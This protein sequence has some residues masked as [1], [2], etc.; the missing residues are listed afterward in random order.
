M[1]ST[2]DRKNGLILWVLLVLL[3]A[4]S[5]ESAFAQASL[6]SHEAIFLRSLELQGALD[7]PFLGYRSLDDETWDHT[8]LIS[9]NLLRY[10]LPSISEIGAFD[11]ELY[12]AD[13]YA[14]YNSA[15]PHGMND[16]A[17]WQGVGFN[18]TFSGGF[19]LQVRNL[20]LTFKPQLLFM[21]NQDFDIMP[22]A[23]P[24]SD[25][26]GYFRGGQDLNQ[27]PGPDSIYDWSW[28][29][30]ELRFNWKNATIGFGTQAVWLGPGLSNAIILTNNAPP[31]PKLD[32]GMRKTETLIGEVEARA[33]WGRMTESDWFNDDEGDDYTLL[34]G[35][36]VAWSPVF[37][38][39]LTLGF[40]RTMLSAWTDQDWDG[41][42]EILVPLMDV[43]MGLDRRDQ[44]A[45]VSAELLFTEVGLRVWFEW[46]RNDHNKWF[47]SVIRYPFHSQA[48]TLGM[49][50][51]WTL[52]DP[53]FE[54]LMQGEIANTESSRDYFT[55]GYSFYGHHIV[56][57]GH[58]NEGQII[59]AGIGTGGNFQRLAFS[60]LHPL[61]S[62]TAYME[63]R[64]RDN[65]Y[66]YYTTLDPHTFN[67][68]LSFG[69][70]TVWPV[71]DWAIAQLGVAWNNNHNPLYNPSNGFSST[72]INSLF[73]SVGLKLIQ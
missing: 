54:L 31:F 12:P 40:Y 63:R 72:I 2:I 67:T 69:L 42:L 39:E 59:G 29:D 11:F 52:P 64:N 14:S 20:S 57:H 51:H 15:Y 38:P 25:G 17:L 50:K 56:I 19:R 8:G 1:N 41:M 33:F 21:G 37:F 71:E 65:D 48:Y 22:T 58:T 46:A 3:I 27:R 43:S 53:R 47:V 73:I 10:P 49:E 45:S 13:W 34:T 66:V 30:S 16:G 6:F 23:Y 62:T 70:D 32:F 36:S 4:P 61:G 55:A 26:F 35:L 44:R 5:S 18:T 28:G 68:E 24:D 7:R 60:L 9:G